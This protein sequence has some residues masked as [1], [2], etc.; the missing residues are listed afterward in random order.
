MNTRK[1]VLI[2]S[3]VMLISIM[4]LGIYAAWYPDRETD[5][6]I[7]YTDKTANRGAGIFA[8]NCRLCH[9]DVGEGGALGAR[10]AAA[11]QLDRPD[12]Q[13]FVDSGAVLTKAA[14]AADTTIQID[15]A[16]KLKA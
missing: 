6:A 5:A 11:P 16:G 1:Q 12:M 8:Q 10:L 15:N 7:S 2:M 3:A 13:G 14:T 9:G 4:V